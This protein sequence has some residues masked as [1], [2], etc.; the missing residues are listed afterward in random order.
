[1]LRSLFMILVLHALVALGWLSVCS[2][3]LAGSVRNP[4]AHDVISIYSDLNEM[5]RGWSGDD[6]H[7]DEACQV[8]NKVSNLLKRMGYCFG[9]R[10]QY[11]GDM[12]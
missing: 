9:K 10:G 4:P 12:W 7:T 1:M 11:G 5:C 8:R 3:S 2:T 6:P